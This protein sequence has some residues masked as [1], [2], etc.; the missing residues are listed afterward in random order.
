MHCRRE[1]HK[2]VC[3]AIYFNIN[4]KLGAAL[5]HNLSQL[6]YAELLGELVEDAELASIGWIVD[7]QLNASDL[8]EMPDSDQASLQTL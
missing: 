7:G 8:Y 5:F 6:I 1:E 3:R 2:G 4:P